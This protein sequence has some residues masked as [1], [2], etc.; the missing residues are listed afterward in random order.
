MSG[1]S[2]T[3]PCPRQV[4]DLSIVVVEDYVTLLD[5]MRTY[6]TP[7]FEDLHT[8]S[9]ARTAMAWLGLNKPDILLCDLHLRDGSGL[10]I[11]AYVKECKPDVAVIICSGDGC[12]SQV[13][14]ELHPV[15]YLYKPF[16][17]Q[18]LRYIVYQAG[19]T[20]LAKQNEQR[21]LPEGVLHDHSNE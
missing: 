6:L 17:P 2:T 8:F 5:M 7:Y 14:P 21:S 9:S 19:E 10:D 16:A 20:L 12:C 13:P 18:E 1:A 11:I 3:E 15:Q 4:G